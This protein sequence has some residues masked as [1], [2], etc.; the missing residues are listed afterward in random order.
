M[1][2]LREPLIRNVAGF[3]D[4][5]SIKIQCTSETAI[6]NAYYDGFVCD[7][8]VNNVFLFSPEGKIVHAAYNFP[9]SWHDSAVAF[10]LI[11]TV[12]RMGDQGLDYAFC[13]DQGF[14]RMGRLQCRFVGPYS[15]QFLRQLDAEIRELLLVRIQRYI[16]LGQSAE[17]G[18]RG[19]QGSF[20][21]LKSR[22][23][24]NSRMQKLIFE[25]ILLNNNFRTT[26][27]G[28]NQIATVFNPHYDQYINLD[29][30]VRI[31]RYF[32]ND[33]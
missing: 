31:A 1:V 16:S 13:V 14:P 18:M 30:Y 29:G 5:C 8:T 23:T 19:L 2:A 9:G 28:F 6:Q 27:V 24:S 20:T 10:D 33:I 15:K 11:E 25:T 4:G 32:I 26:Y 12:L 21:R 3:V 22:L 17:W 7:T